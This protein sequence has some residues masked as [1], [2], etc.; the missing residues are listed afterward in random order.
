MRA[1]AENPRVAGLMG[2]N[3]NN[4]IVFTFAMAAAL[5][6]IA[7]VLVAANYGQAQFAMGFLPGLK[8]FTAAVL[9]GIGN[10]Y[11]AM[12]GGLLLGIIEALGAGYIGELTGGFLGSHYQGIF[13]FAVLIDP[14]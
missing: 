6:A 5:A 8:R 12:V 10:L 1:T 7:G 11:G 4:V 14:F 9:G 3:S 13:A 2:V